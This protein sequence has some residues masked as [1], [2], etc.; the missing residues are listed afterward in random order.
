VA[1]DFA[2]RGQYAAAIPEWVKALAMDPTDAHVLNNYGQ[3]LARAG[4]VDEAIIQLQKAIAAK[5][6]YPEAENN[7]TFVLAG[8]G[9]SDEAIAHYRRAIDERPGYADAHSNLGRMLT[10]QGHLPE[11]VE[12]F[13][14]ALAINPEFAEAHNYLVLPWYRRTTSMKPPWST[15]APL[16]RSKVVL[17][18]Q[19]RIDDALKNFSK[20]IDL[21]PSCVGVE[22]NLGHAMLAGGLVDK[23]IPHLQKAVD[24]SPK[25][26]ELQSDLA[27][28]LEQR[29]R[30]DEAIPH[31]E[32]ALQL[33]PHLVRAHHYLGVALVSK[34]QTAQ[35]VAQWRDALRDDPDNVRI[36]NETAW[37]LATSL[38][39]GLRD[40]KEAVRLASRA[41]EL[42]STQDP[43][44]L[45]TLAAAYAEVGEYA[46]AVETDH[47][48]VNLAT[49]Q[50]IPDLVSIL[51]RRMV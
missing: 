25:S 22:S 26:A 36:L 50:G 37:V 31:F 28:A 16:M 23:A 24:I 4:N 10:E 39:Q 45:G 29:G 3:T 12:E 34:G 13:Q 5:P 33:A 51:S 20:A 21:D 9:L 11:A 6:D 1:E 42:T 44:I 27:A 8:A 18:R 35:A 30:V 32:Q 14:Q 7:L 49:Q 46:K 2:K 40:G 19:R 48:A 41:A 38:D 17:S 43:S 15:A 47:Q